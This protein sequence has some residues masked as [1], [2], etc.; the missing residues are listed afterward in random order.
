LTNKKSC[1]NIVHASVQGMINSVDRCLTI[2]EILSNN[3]SCGITELAEKLGIDKSSVYR[4]VSTMRGK[5]YVEQI[6]GSKRYVLGLK[7]L[8]IG[9]RLVDK[10]EL[11]SRVR[12]LLERL[13]ELSGETSHLAVLR[14]SS[15]VYIDRVASSEVVAVQTSIGAH[16]PV[17]CAATGKAILAFLSQEARQDV[18]NAIEREGIEVFTDKTISSIPDLIKE[19][20]R[21]RERGYAFDNEERHSGVRCL[22]A[23]IMN[24]E[25]VV[26]ASIGIS[27]PV[28][29]LSNKRIQDLVGMVKEIAEKAS[30]SIG[31]VASAEALK[32]KK[33]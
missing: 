13:N 18:L 1:F 30:A 28:S 23:P 20:A 2:L 3:S 4:L 12:P 21:V 6:P 16:E 19:L 5:D 17:Y 11:A 9:N 7:I 33:S 22:A 29:R 26:V 15:V 8:E 25:H 10:M 32:T 14:K 31:N 27:G 24:H